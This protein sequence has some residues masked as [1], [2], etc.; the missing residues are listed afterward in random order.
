MAGP[1]VI[2]M[3]SPS[4][5]PAGEIH[6]AWSATPQT[7]TPP[8]VGMVTASYQPVCPPTMLMPSSRAASEI[9]TIMVF[10]SLSGHVGGSRRVY[11]MNCGCIPVTATSLAPICTVNHPIM[12][13]GSPG[14]GKIGSS[15]M[16]MTLPSDKSRTAASRPG[17][18]ATSV[19]AEKAP[20]WFPS[21]AFRRLGDGLPTRRSLMGQAPSEYGLDIQN[22]PSESAN[23]TFAIVNGDMS[24]H[25]RRDGFHMMMARH[26][27]FDH[28]LRISFNRSLHRA[29][30][31][32]H[33]GTLN[34]WNKLRDFLFEFLAYSDWRY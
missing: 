11:V 30:E 16:A 2:R 5:A 1:F 34:Y 23:G 19:C 33:T 22:F 18:G 14:A 28:L 27:N 7:V 17:P 13:S 32:I 26:N 10:A 12:S 20:K 6:A 21:S 3:R 31:I 24:E 9:D 4:R 25:A 29:H 8:T 15:A